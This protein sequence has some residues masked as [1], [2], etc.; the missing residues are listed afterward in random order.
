MEH[1]LSQASFILWNQ[2]PFTD[3]ERYRATVSYLSNIIYAANLSESVLY[4]SLWYTHKISRIMACVPKAPSSELRI[5]ITSLI[6]ADLY[7]NDSALLINSWAE[8]SRFDIPELIKMKTEF[9]LLLNYDLHISQ[10][11]FS[12]WKKT[13]KNIVLDFTAHGFVHKPQFIKWFD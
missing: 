2:A 8:V 4:L 1:C 3:F 5:L 12:Q 10:V 7:L 6:L 9:I 11:E 13:V